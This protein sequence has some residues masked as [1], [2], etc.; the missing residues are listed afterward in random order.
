MRDE[1]LLLNGKWVEGESVLSVRN[2]F[3]GAEV[4]RISQAGDAQIEAALEAAYQ[5][6]GR[7][8]AQT[9]GKRRAILS[10]VAALLEER[11]EEFVER[12]VDEAGKPVTLARAEVRRAIECFTLAAS[13]L[14]R[15]GG[16]V[17][18]VDF[19]E[20]SAGYACEVR[21]FPV[22]LVAG[23]V[24]FNFP[25]NL[26]VHKVAPALAV[27]APILV[28]PPPQA[29]SAQL[30]LGELV[31]E[32]G[33]DPAA[34]QVLP[35][36]NVRAERLA[37]DARVRV[38]S[39]TGSARV[40]WHLKGLAHGRVVLELGGNAAVIVGADADVEWAAARCVAGAFGYAGQVC[41][42]AQRIFVDRQVAAPFR[43]ELLARTEALV[44]GDPRDPEVS[45]G[46]VIDVTS[47]DRIDAWVREAVLGGA[48]VLS[49]RARE[50]QLLGPT[51]LTHAPR[52]SKVMREEI[53]GPVVVLEEVSSFDEGLARANEGAY[54]LQAGIFTYDV[55]RIRK[56]FQ[57]LEVG[58][59]IV[60][61]APTF[62]SDNAP[63]GGVK[64]SGLG[65]E[66]I[67]YA[68]DDFTEPR[69]L[70]TS[71]H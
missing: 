34:M 24:P 6:R 50:G 36:D 65:R 5:A 52:D 17:V 42:K 71:R 32:A 68:M 4:A 28:K 23:I 53:F 59:V 1:K 45:V 9:T 15:F 57:T 64:G 67:R 51:V 29:P 70:I 60:N 22:G 49:T 55:R 12:I 37:T 66:G 25:L 35:C 44:R 8:A 10:R 27:G 18:P 56:A 14:A 39:F 20:G 19:D 3:D 58:A 13:E 7:L 26:G 2:P 40:G 54:G 21:R 61:D 16:E 30:L 33:A 69:A 48:K 62:R 47:A 41:I 38:L 31:L 46:P 43:D 11:G 63:Y